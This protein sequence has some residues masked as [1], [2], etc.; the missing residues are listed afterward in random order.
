MYFL[1]SFRQRMMTDR[2]AGEE[3]RFLCEEIGISGILSKETTKPRRGLDG[4][5]AQLHCSWLQCPRRAA[6]C[7]GDVGSSKQRLQRVAL[8]QYPLTLSSTNN[9]PHC[10]QRTKCHQIKKTN[11]PT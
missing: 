9:K 7:G 2:S 3:T 8:S 1:L 5:A 11:H 6:Q 10:L 4:K